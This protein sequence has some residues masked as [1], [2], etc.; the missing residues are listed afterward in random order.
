MVDTTWMAV[1][2]DEPSQ[3]ELRRKHFSHHV[4]KLRMRD[5]RL[6]GLNTDS[7]FHDFGAYQ[8]ESVHDVKSSPI[9]GDPS[10]A[11]IL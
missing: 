7:Y 2:L 10:S 11:S 4:M 1:G 9:S 6:N 5:Q 8:S 3:R